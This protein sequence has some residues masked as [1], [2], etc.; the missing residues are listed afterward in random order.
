MVAFQIMGKYSAQKGAGV[1]SC[2][3]K[4]KK[5]KCT[6]LSERSHPSEL[7]Q[8]TVST[9]GCHAWATGRQRELGQARRTFRAVTLFCVTL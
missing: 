2:E 7:A 8:Y 5:L 9:I 6:W 3:K 4:W 1:Q